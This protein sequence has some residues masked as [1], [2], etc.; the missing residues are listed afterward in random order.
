MIDN[1]EKKIREMQELS[2]YMVAKYGKA[3][4][5]AI[6]KLNADLQYDAKYMLRP[7]L[8]LTKE[9]KDALLFYIPEQDASLI[10]RKTR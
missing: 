4:M 5:S 8:F 1:Y 7:E 6:A 2:E 10:A 3:Y 9:E